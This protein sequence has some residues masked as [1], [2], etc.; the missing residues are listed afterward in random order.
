MG[1]DQVDVVNKWLLKSQG[2]GHRAPHAGYYN[3]GN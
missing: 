2:L 1:M 3:S